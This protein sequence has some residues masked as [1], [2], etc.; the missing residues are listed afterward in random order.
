MSDETKQGLQEAEA[1]G[2]PAQPTQGPGAAMKDEKLW[3]REIREKTNRADDDAQAG[4]GLSVKGGPESERQK[5][6]A[7]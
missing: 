6:S 1:T 7:P 2:N 4:L 5:D 3:L